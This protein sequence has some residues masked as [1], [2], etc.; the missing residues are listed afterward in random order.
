MVALRWTT[1]GTL[2]DRPLLTPMLHS[3]TR[4]RQKRTESSPPRADPRAGSKVHWMGQGQ[5]IKREDFAAEM[6]RASHHP[7][8]PKEAGYS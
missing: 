5:E 1:P 6:E 2:V 8:V 3:L 7:C 4:E